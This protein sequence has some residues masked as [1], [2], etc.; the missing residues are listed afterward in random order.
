MAFVYICNAL[1]LSSYRD[2][3]TYDLLI[4]TFWCKDLWS[5][6]SFDD[7]C[8]LWYELHLFCFL[9]TNFS[10]LHIRILKKNSA[11]FSPSLA[12]KAVL[13]T[14]ILS[15]T[16]KYSRQNFSLNLW[17]STA[18]FGCLT[19]LC[20]PEFISNKDGWY[21]DDEFRIWTITKYWKSE[22]EEA[23][24][25]ISWEPASYG[26]VSM[27]LLFATV[28]VRQLFV[29]SIRCEANIFYF[30]FCQVNLIIAYI[31]CVSWY[32]IRSVF[33]CSCA[34]V[35]SE[36]SALCTYVQIAEGDPQF[37]TQGKMSTTGDMMP[38]IYPKRCCGH[39]LL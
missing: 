36:T 27:M 35:N 24:I 10:S 5:R 13:H 1:L 17:F 26:K 23:T 29:F 18:C 12:I 32:E 15:L 6:S 21:E 19:M 22:H 3:F 30:G 2:L 8:C 7:L 33:I 20:W 31:R 9:C 39:Q 16:S 37:P 4:S 28:L 11:W 14:F 38:M 25:I 34:V